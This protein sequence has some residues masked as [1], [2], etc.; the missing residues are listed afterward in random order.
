MTSRAGK[1]VGF[2]PEAELAAPY[3]EHVCPPETPLIL[4]RWRNVNISGFF[5]LKTYPRVCRKE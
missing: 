2:N 3:L 5:G 4:K 1:H